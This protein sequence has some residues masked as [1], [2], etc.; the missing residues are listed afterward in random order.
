MKETVHV[1]TIKVLLIKPG[2]SPAEIEVEDTLE[3]QQKLVGGYIEMCMPFEDEVALICNEEG[4]ICRLPMNRALRNEKGEVTDIV[5]GDFFL[6]YAPC[7][8]D[9]FLSLPPDLMQ[10]Y[11]EKFRCPERFYMVDSEIFPVKYRPSKEEME[12]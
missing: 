4:K 9:G 11:K 8:S 7:E 1:D 12:R 10:K 6:C 3:A 5:F 2:K